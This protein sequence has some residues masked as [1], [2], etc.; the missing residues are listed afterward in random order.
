MLLSI[1]LLAVLVLIFGFSAYGFYK[2]SK[3]VKMA[4]WARKNKTNARILL[5]F[6]NVLMAMIGVS[7]GMLCTKLNLHLSVYTIYAG[8]GLFI[9]GTVFFPS[10]DKGSP[11]I[12]KRYRRKQFLSLCRVAGSS[13][14]MIAFANEYMGGNTAGLVT[15]AGVSPVILII[16]A[17]LGLIVFGVIILALSCSLACN[18]YDGAAML[19]FFGGGSALIVGYVLLLVR[20]VQK[21]RERKTG[22]VRKPSPEDALD[23]PM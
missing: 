13:L 7:I 4:K 23:E 3:D 17:S 20:I 9:F 21:N 15:T 2:Q 6:F 8:L 18:G 16:L 5:V 12:Y 10:S 19:V 11:D 1:L 14:A 22:Q